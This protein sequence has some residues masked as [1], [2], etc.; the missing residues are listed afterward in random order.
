MSI[1]TYPLDGVTYSAADAE[2]YL[3]TRVS[4]V[5]SADEH[6]ACSVTGDREI[7][8]SPGLA[9]IKNGEYFGKS[10]A[11]KENV[12]LN[13][14]VADGALPRMDRVVLR[15][16][17]AA[18]ASSIVLVQGTPSASP[19]APALQRT[20]LVYE[21]GI[22]VI[23]VP[24]ASLTV[25]AANV[26]DTRLDEA[27]CGVMRDGVTGIPTAELY[28]QAAAII[29][30]MRQLLTSLADGTAYMLR[31]IYDSDGD[32]VVD[33]AKT[34]DVAGFTPAKMEFDGETLNITLL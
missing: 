32:G 10:V 8:V 23:L 22:A 5:Y 28:R 33:K 9:W 30:D 7:T 20:E 6:F 16:D 18:N 14:P 21:L 11:S 24:A 13:V 34:L 4:G 26:Q 15:F 3:C 29:A 12:A 17:K 2:T 1:I 27:V 31:E 25:T 19:A